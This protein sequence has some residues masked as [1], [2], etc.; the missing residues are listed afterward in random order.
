MKIKIEFSNIENIETSYRENS[1]TATLT[2][3]HVLEYDEMESEDIKDTIGHHETN[4]LIH[5]NLDGYIE[6]S[7]TKELLKMQLM[8]TKTL[9]DR[10]V[11]IE[12]TT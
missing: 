8:I 6:E 1:M 2:K 12:E 7:E 3:P 11:N 10:N 5:D 9:S 4:V